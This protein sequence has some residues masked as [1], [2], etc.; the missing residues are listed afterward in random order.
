MS[1]CGYAG[2]EQE[3]E[4]LLEL[5]TFVDRSAYTAFGLSYYACPEPVLAN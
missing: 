2:T 5:R 4:G 1:V 3:S